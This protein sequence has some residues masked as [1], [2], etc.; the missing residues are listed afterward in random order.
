MAGCVIRVSIN[1][2][3]IA[4]TRI[5]SSAHRRERFIVSEIRPIFEEAYPGTKTAERNADIETTL[6]PPGA[7]LAFRRSWQHIVNRMG[8]NRFCVTDAT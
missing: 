5:P 1:P 2:G 8:P 6:A 3:A 4:L 7:V